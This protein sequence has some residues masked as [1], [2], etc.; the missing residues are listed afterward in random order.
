M[1]EGGWF[2]KLMDCRDQGGDGLGFQD[3]GNV[4]AELILV[5]RSNHVQEVRACFLFATI[6]IR[7]YAL[8]ASGFMVLGFEVAS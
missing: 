1:E 8:P 7:G 5:E 6:R 4:P 2:D 3:E